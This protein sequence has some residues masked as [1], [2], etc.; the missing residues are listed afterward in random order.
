MVTAVTTTTTTTTAVA[1]ATT[2]PFFL[3]YRLAVRRGR[4]GREYEIE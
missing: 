3:Q 4:K 1:P 2:N